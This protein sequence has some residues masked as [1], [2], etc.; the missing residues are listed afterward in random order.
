M[1][2]ILYYPVLKSKKNRHFEKYVRFS[3]EITFKASRREVLSSASST[4]NTKHNNKYGSTASKAKELVE[5]FNFSFRYI[6]CP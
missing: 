3:K 4:M 1:K 5:S 6:F 2:G